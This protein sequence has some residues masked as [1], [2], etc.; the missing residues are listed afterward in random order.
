LATEPVVPAQQPA[1]VLTSRD[2]HGI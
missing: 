2:L 1:V